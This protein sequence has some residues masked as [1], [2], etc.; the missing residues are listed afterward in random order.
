MRKTKRERL[1]VLPSRKV[2]QDWETTL[3]PWPSLFGDASY[4]ESSDTTWSECNVWPSSR[5]PANINN[6]YRWS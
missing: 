4:K 6:P 3:L 2:S 5:Y 1:Q